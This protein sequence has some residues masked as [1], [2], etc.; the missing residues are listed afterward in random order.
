MNVSLSELLMLINKKSE[1][2]GELYQDVI[3]NSVVTKDREVTGDNEI[4]LNDVEDFYKVK[5]RFDNALYELMK[6]KNI[7]A[8]SNSSV[9]LPNGQT[10]IE[11]I[12]TISSLK[13]E[14]GLYDVLALKKPSLNR[15]FDGSGGSSYYRINDLNFD[16]NSIKENRNLVKNKI[17]EIEAAIY[18]INATTFVE[19]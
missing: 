12:N 15:M 10:I 13:R 1:E 19:I 18:N 4:I 5:M 9:K 3:K 2:V 16:L 8:L 6:Y 14:L 11:A 7:L 17:T